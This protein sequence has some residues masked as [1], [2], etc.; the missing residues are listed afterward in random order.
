[1]LKADAFNLPEKAKE[2]SKEL[3]NTVCENLHRSRAGFQPTK[4]V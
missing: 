2:Q 4:E 3:A 1:M